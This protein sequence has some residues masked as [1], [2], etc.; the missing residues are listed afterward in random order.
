MATPPPCWREAT[1]PVGNEGTLNNLLRPDKH[2]LLRR[3]P[4][5][6]Q[7]VDSAWFVELARNYPPHPRPLS[8]PRLNVGSTDD[9]TLSGV[10][11]TTFYFSAFFSKIRTC[12]QGRSSLVSTCFRGKGAISLRTCRSLIL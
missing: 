5:Y 8:E 11:G 10:A 2:N 9:N 12:C 1:D 3:K 4:P 6:S 7:E